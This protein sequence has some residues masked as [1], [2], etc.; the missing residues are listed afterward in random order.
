[1]RMSVDCKQMLLIISLALEARERG[2]FILGDIM[3]EIFYCDSA[4]FSSESENTEPS[5]LALTRNSKVSI[6][7]SNSLIKYRLKNFT[8]KQP[9]YL[10]NYFK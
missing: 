5:R 2:V 8:E 6:G 9:H 10:Q 7:G 3:E 4:I 1:M